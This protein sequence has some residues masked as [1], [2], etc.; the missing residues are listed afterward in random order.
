MAGTGKSCVVDLLSRFLTYYASRNGEQNSGDIVLRS[1]STGV[2]AHNIEGST[3]HS[4]FQPPIQRQAIDE[5]S[6]ERLTKL[7]RT[8]SSCWLLIIDEKSMMGCRFLHKVDARLRQILCRSDDFFGGLNI[9]FCGDLGQLKPVGD[10]H[11]Y[12]GDGLAA[13]RLAYQAFN[14]TIVLEE[15]MRQQGQIEDCLFRE[16][17]D[18]LRDGP[19]G[20]GNWDFLV[21]RTRD[22]LSAEEWSSFDDAIRL[23]PYRN[24]VASYNMARL[25]V[26]Q[27]S[28]IRVKSR[29]DGSGA[30]QVDEDD[31]DGLSKTM[32][33]FVGARVMITQNIWTKE[34]L[35]NGAMSTVHS[36]LWNDSVQDPFEII[37][38]IVMLHVD[39]Y[40]GVG[41]VD[42]DGQRVV[43]ILLVNIT[44]E[45]G[46]IVCHR[47]QLSLRLAFAII[48]HKS[49]GLTLSRAVVFLPFKGLDT[50]NAYVAL[51]RVRTW[52]E[53][54][55]EESFSYDAFS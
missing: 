17:L 18:Q 34:G 23:Y 51:S 38:A 39:D 31:V 54:A 2:A 52:N 47:T 55:K 35:V 12:S 46:N 29:N 41:C 49:Q 53:F 37:S 45:V 13:G 1:A 27:K 8:L 25:V 36:I 11:L 19:I 32:F 15:L 7:Q 50:T 42:I 33:L 44:F 28:V 10:S 16:T 3:L 5:L 9:L 6:K 40:D 22:R 21:S 4:L 14:R 43:S 30:E 20:K 48:V 26:L 24:Q